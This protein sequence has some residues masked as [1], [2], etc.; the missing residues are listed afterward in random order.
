MTLEGM[1]NYSQLN[2]HV[3]C[4]HTRMRFSWMSDSSKFDDDTII[5]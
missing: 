4:A 2:R 1:R 5:F 3:S